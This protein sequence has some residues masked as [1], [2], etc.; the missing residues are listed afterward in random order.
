VR[1]RP[2]LCADFHVFSLPLPLFRP[3]FPSL[4]M[5]STPLLLSRRLPNLG[6]TSYA[7]YLASD[8]WKDFRSRYLLS[9]ST[10]KRCL[11]CKSDLITL[12]HVTYGTLGEEL[13]EDVIPLCWP[14][15]DAVHKCL[16]R[17]NLPLEDSYWVIRTLK[18]IMAGERL[19]R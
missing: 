5:F 4:I 16:K 12:H 13:F 1:I 9:P 14:H 7:E 2:N 11:V 6:F 17:H 15:H 8:H 19:R 18:G 3:S 10:P